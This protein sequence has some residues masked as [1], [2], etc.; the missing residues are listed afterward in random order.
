MILEGI[1]RR[2]SS[3][4]LTS[5]YLWM[6]AV[7]FVFCFSCGRN[8]NNN[9]R[10]EIDY[11]S[12]E[13]LRTEYKNLIDSN[14]EEKICDLVKLEL[15]WML[16]GI[17]QPEEIVLD[18]LFK[19]TGSGCVGQKKSSG[20]ASDL[21]NTLKSGIKKCRIHSQKKS[22]DY[23]TF[24]IW[25]GQ[26]KQKWDK[27]FFEIGK[28]L[29]NTAM[30]IETRIVMAQ[31]L[32]FSLGILEKVSPTEKMNFFIRAV[33]FQCPESG[34]IWGSST[35]GIY[36]NLKGDISWCIP[37]CKQNPISREIFSYSS[38]RKLFML[39]CSHLDL[40]LKSSEYLKYISPDNYLFFKTV[41]F[42]RKNL[43]ILLKSNDKFVKSNKKWLSETLDKLNSQVFILSFP[44]MEASEKG[45]V[46]V[47]LS[48]A[49]SHTP[50]SFHFV[51][52]D[53]FGEMRAGIRPELNVKDM[54]IKHDYPGVEYPG[55]FR[56]A[57]REYIYRNNLK[58]SPVFILDEKMPVGFLVEIAQILSELK[59]NLIELAF[60]DNSGMIRT[61]TAG[62]KKSY[63]PSKTI[64]VSIGK[65]FI[66]ATSDMEYVKAHPFTSGST[67]DFSSLR[68]YLEKL[69][70]KKRVRSEIILKLENGVSWDN[71]G[72]IIGYIFTN[73]SG[74]KL[75]SQI[76]V[77]IKSKE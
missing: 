67:H 32:K 9:N 70:W 7:V 11:S 42:H 66:T 64:L 30:E 28:K 34:G 49:A 76:S 12:V 74:R 10:A 57:L 47:P 43:S 4:N 38:R 6:S 24:L 20:C 53:R 31:A 14:D 51:Q 17:V 39:R 46:S 54:N 40:G 5:I 61:F 44:V 69:K 72:R 62:I 59:I 19:I 68:M 45:S 16:L 77:L 21:F 33:G 3:I 75:F 26:L 50:D 65:G 71:A 18:E 25:Q 23:M 8:K 36:S 15:R 13:S 48:R 1:F 55:G 27:D 29:L 35:G 73:T 22:D 37:D 41:Q 52:I 56:K 58:V 60:R 2:K 63:D